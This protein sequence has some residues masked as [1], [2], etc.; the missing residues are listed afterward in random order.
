MAIPYFWQHFDKEN[1]SIWFCEYKYPE[2]LKR[3]FMACNL[4]SGMLQRI[5]GLRKIGFASMIIFGEDY[6][7]SISGVWLFK[8][9]KLGFDV[10]ICIFCN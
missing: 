7:I 10:S 2:E 1:C 8:G 9:Q 6:N 3:I 5:D 4:V